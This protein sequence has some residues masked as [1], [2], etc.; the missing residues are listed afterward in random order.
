MDTET[1]SDVYFSANS[2]VYETALEGESDHDMMDWEDEAEEIEFF[3]AAESAEKGGTD[4]QVR[5]DE[6]IAALEIPDS[7][8]VLDR[9]SAKKALKEM[10]FVYSPVDLNPDIDSGEETDVVD[11]ELLGAKVLAG[12][13]TTCRERSAHRRR[14]KYHRERNSIRDGTADSVIVQ[15][16]I[17]K[18]SKQRTRFRAEA[19]EIRESRGFLPIE[20][21]VLPINLQNKPRP[22]PKRAEHL[23]KEEAYEK[24]LENLRIKYASRTEEQKQADSL[25]WKQKNALGK[26]AEFEKA[27]EIVESSSTEEFSSGE[28]A[29]AGELLRKYEKKFKK[30]WAQLEIEVQNEGLKVGNIIEL[31]LFEMEVDIIVFGRCSGEWIQGGLDKMMLGNLI[32]ANK[33]EIDFLLPNVRVRRH[34]SIAWHHTKAWVP[35]PKVHPDDARNPLRADDDSNKFANGRF[36]EFFDNADGTPIAW[37]NRGID[38]S[39]IDVGSYLVLEARYSQQE[40]WLVF[41]LEGDW[42]RNASFGLRFDPDDAWFSR[43]QPYDGKWY[44]MFELHRLCDAI[45]GRRWPGDEKYKWLLEQWELQIHWRDELSRAHSS[46][47]KNRIRL[48]QASYDGMN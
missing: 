30:G 1:Q 27:K 22:T 9:K 25:K 3:E 17:T 38:G 11:W 42:V 41:I 19:D 14:V 15:R 43:S 32:V 46:G 23:S 47:S 35:L 7:G 40:I 36:L 4:S 6:S 5:E 24:R 20:R 8:P 29:E 45:R 28:I 48:A 31:N 34:E 33:F 12:Q 37:L 10:R 44:I 13:K 16:Y 26:L 2:T 21:P 39:S 18:I